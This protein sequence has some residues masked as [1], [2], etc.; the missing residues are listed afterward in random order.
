MD[1]IEKTSAR[2]LLLNKGIILQSGAI[3]QNKINLISGAMTAPL[4]ETIWIF[5][6]YDIGAMERISNIFTHLYNE[7]REAE[8]MAVLRILYDLP[9]LQFPEDVELLA[10]HTEARQYFLFSFLLD[11]NDCIQSFI[12]EAA[13]E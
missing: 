7:S 13:G 11:M 9:G 5:S 4:L 2:S 8:M 3:C 10:G 12:S 1:I 6:G